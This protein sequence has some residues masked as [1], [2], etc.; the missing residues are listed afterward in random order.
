MEVTFAEMKCA[1]YFLLCRE[2]LMEH[3]DITPYFFKSESGRGEAVRYILEDTVIE[4]AKRGA[5]YCHILQI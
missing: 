3:A 4:F 1:P 5:P 2:G